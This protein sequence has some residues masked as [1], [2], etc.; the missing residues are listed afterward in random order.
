MGMPTGSRPG[1]NRPTAARRT[2]TRLRSMSTRSRFPVGP[3]SCADRSRSS[4]GSCSRRPRPERASSA[5]RRASSGQPPFSPAHSSF[6][7]KIV[8]RSRTGFFVLG[9]DV[10]FGLEPCAQEDC[11]PKGRREQQRATSMKRLSKPS[12]PRMNLTAGLISA[13][14]F[15]SFVILQSEFQPRGLRSQTP[16][17][18]SIGAYLSTSPLR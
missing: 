8:P 12:Q 11:Q 4:R 6:A 15:A 13:T 10:G 2:V 17:P 16:S 5:P 3:E 14:T 18:S 1:R 7:G 9:L